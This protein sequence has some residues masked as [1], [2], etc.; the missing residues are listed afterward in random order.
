MTYE[1]YVGREKDLPVKCSGHMT[2]VELNKCYFGTF[3]RISR[4]VF[5]PLTQDCDLGLGQLFANYKN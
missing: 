4:N 2:K 1:T 3:L 5:R